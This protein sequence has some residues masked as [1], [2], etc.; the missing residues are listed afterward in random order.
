MTLRHS[1]EDP[2]RSFLYP[3]YLDTARAVIDYYEDIAIDD[4]T[5]SKFIDAYGEARANWVEQH[6]D[7]FDLD[8][9]LKMEAGGRS[10]DKEKFNELHWAEFRRCEEEHP[11]FVNP[12]HAR[13]VARSVQMAR[14]AWWSLN[15]EEEAK[16]LAYKITLTNGVQ[17]PLGEIKTR[18]LV[19]EY[20]ADLV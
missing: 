3:R 20:E 18:Y 8:L 7:T 4:A 14:I 16:L 12:V 5:I 17:Q 10:V 13:D 6:M 2:N 11:T 19:G 15:D 1:P 9:K